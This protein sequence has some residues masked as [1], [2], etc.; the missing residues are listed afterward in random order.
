MIGNKIRVGMMPT[1]AFKIGETS[2]SNNVNY[3]EQIK[4]GSVHDWVRYNYGTPKECE[5]CGFKS[6]NTYQFNWANIS[7][8]Y[9]RDREDWLRL[10]RKCHHEYDN[11]SQKIW[12]SRKSGL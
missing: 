2:G 6:D 12:A 3:K 9:K 1:N 10:C 8:E 4:Y 5:Q 11:I 7:K